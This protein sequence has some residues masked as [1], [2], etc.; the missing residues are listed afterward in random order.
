MCVQKQLVPTRSDFKRVPS[1]MLLT[2]PPP[3]PSQHKHSSYDGVSA[4]TAVPEFA[5]LK[6]LWKLSGRELPLFICLYY[7]IKDSYSFY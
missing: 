5:V 6:L 2:F 1:V 7:V 4:S 3:V